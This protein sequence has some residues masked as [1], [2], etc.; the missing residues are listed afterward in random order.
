MQHEYNTVHYILEKAKTS[1]GLQI[2]AQLQVRSHGLVVNMTDKMKIFELMA[3]IKEIYHISDIREVLGG[4]YM[5]IPII[6]IRT[7]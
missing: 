7:A 2:P 5:K 6:Y 1:L 3:S 4:Y